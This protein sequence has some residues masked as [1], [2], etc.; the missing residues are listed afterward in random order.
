MTQTKGEK[1]YESKPGAV[2]KFCSTI[3]RHHYLH[4]YLLLLANRGAQGE[5]CT[6]LDAIR[7]EVNLQ[8]L[9][10]NKRGIEKCGRQWTGLGVRVCTV[11]TSRGTH[12]GDEAN[13]P[14]CVSRKDDHLA[15]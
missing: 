13:V 2:F 6:I 15:F 5:R 10:G 4:L 9:F 8:F 14:Y 3:G 1:K 11:R 12:P 7:M